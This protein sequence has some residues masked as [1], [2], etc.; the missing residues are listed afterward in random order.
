MGRSVKVSRLI[1]LGT[2]QAGEW[3]KCREAYNEAMES[4]LLAGIAEDDDEVKHLK[5]DLQDVEVELITDPETYYAEME[6][7]LAPFMHGA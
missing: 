6:Q 1:V 3:L 5:E 2:F 4:L 7:R